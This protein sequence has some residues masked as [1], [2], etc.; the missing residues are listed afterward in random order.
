MLSDSKN[1]VKGGT[2]ELEN[3]TREQGTGTA[4]GEF[5]K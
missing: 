1:I 4:S 5:L 2:E 3:E